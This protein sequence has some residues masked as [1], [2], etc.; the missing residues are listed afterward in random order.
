LAVSETGDFGV[1]NVIYGICTSS[2]FGDGD[3]IVIGRPIHRVVDN[4]LENGSEANGAVDLGLLLGGEV[5]AL[6]VAATFDV[7]NTSVGPNVLVV[8]DELAIGV[9]GEGAVAA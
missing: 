4:V 8:A 5:D 1:G 7:E 3:V 2:V 6:G 9:S